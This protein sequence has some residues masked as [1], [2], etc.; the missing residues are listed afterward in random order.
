MEIPDL[1]TMTV[2]EWTPIITGHLASHVDQAFGIM[3]DRE[4]APEGW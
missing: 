3:H 1:G 4:V 2:A